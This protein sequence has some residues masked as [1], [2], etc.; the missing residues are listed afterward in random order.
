MKEH[1]N[2]DGIVVVTFAAQTDWLAERLGRMMGE[3]FGNSHVYFQGNGIGVIFVAGNLTSEQIQR[4]GLELWSPNLQVKDLPMT[5]DDWPY[6]YM[7]SRRIPA[8]YWQALLVVGIL[9]LLIMRRS[10]PEV[11]RPDLQFWLLGAG[12]LLIEFT[13][14]TRLALLFGTTWLVN[15]LAI[16]GVLLMILGANLIVLRSKSINLGVVYVLMFISLGLVYFFPLEALNRLTP[17][18]WALSSIVLLTLPLFFSGMIFSELLRRA[19]ETSRPLASNLTGSVFGGM[20][21]YTSILWGVQSL[22]VT[23]TVIYALGFLTFIWQLRG[24]QLIK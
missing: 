20:L 12:F 15:A 14:I 3:I 4:A 13:S 23:A 18:P 1:L 19:G 21:E 5:T 7:R 10:F 22:Y 24:K 9:A 8:A 17:F 16:S 6:L 11:L 2:N